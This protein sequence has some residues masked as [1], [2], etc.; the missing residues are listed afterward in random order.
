MTDLSPLRRRMIEDMTARNLSPANQRSYLH[1]VSKIS[2]YFDRS[3]AWLRLEDVW[4]FQ[5]LA[6]ET[7]FPLEVRLRYEA[8]YR[9]GEITDL[10][11]AERFR[12]P[13]DYAR[14]SVYPAYMQAVKE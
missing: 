2:R 9:A 12:I 13:E 10:L 4:A 1:A 11:L 5:V 3:P 14:R 6:I 7:L 8:R